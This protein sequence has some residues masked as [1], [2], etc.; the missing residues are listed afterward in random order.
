MAVL[1]EKADLIARECRSKIKTRW[2]L[3]SI[4]RLQKGISND[5]RL[6]LSDQRVKR[7]AREDSSKAWKMRSC[8]FR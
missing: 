8:I 5:P 7:F 4:V 3:D 2:F 6:I 1:I